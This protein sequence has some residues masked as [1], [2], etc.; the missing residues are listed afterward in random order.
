VIAISLSAL[1][2]PLLARAKSYPLI[3]SPYVLRNLLIYFIFYIPVVVGAVDKWITCSFWHFLIFAHPHKPALQADVSHVDNLS[4]W[5]TRGGYVVDKVPALVDNFA[6]HSPTKKT[7]WISYPQALWTC[8]EVIHGSGKV[9][10]S[11]PR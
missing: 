2:Q 1:Q 7:M 6:L 10:I 8:L 11:Y 4:T 9:W 5:L 3:H